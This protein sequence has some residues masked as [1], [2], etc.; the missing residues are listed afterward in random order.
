MRPMCWLENLH[1]VMDCELRVLSAAAGSH[2]G[3]TITADG[4]Q[5]STPPPKTLK[6]ELWRAIAAEL[7]S[8]RGLASYKGM[9]FTTSA[10]LVS[11]HDSIPDGSPIR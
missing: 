7:K 11:V 10:G 4:V 6:S 8:D 3:D 2:P 5:S 1:Y 9:P